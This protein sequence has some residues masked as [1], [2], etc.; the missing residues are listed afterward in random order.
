V[1]FDFDDAIYLRDTS[2]AN[3]LFDRL[4]FPSKTVTLC[5]RSAVVSAGSRY[6]ANWALEHART[7]VTVPTTIDLER[8]VRPRPP[9]ER[10]RVVVGWAGSSTSLGHLERFAPML[11]ELAA[12]REVE[13]RVVANR[14]PELPDLAV[15]WRPWSAQTEVQEIADFDVGI[16]P[17]PDD[18]W[19]RGKCPMKELQY[20]ALEVPVV[21]SA[22][23]ATREAVRHGESGFSVTTQAEWLESLMQLIDSPELRRR[24]GRAGRAIVERE[25]ATVVS[26][27]RLLDALAAESEPRRTPAIRL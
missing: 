22:V 6:L 25:Y 7:V 20:M 12:R 27:R 18:P 24:M 16:K 19:S 5:R 1:I 21:C 9:Q 23:G 4:K 13:I 3:P 2:G 17:L 26:V 10:K 15:D 14:R 8:Y 11:R